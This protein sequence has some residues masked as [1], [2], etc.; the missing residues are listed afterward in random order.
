MVRAGDSGKG[1]LENWYDSGIA[2]P[3][4]LDRK[5]I[6]DHEIERLTRVFSIVRI[7]G[8]IVGRLG[9]DAG[10]EELALDKRRSRRVSH[11][12]EQSLRGWQ[13]RKP[14]VQMTEE[15]RLTAIHLNWEAFGP[16][17]LTSIEGRLRLV[18]TWA[19]RTDDTRWGRTAVVK[20]ENEYKW[21][22][23]AL[24]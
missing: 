10:A 8:S 16:A 2:L 24:R 17:H 19:M 7:T 13:V 18:A 15:I 6:T 12:L 11:A 21:C 14:K 22:E 3:S 4:Y 5:I 1:Y 20:L 9:P 23:Y